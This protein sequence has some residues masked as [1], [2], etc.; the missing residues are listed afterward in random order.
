MKWYRKAAEQNNA[1]AQDNLGVCYAKGRGVKQDSTEAVKWY[2]KAAEQNYAL[3]QHNLGFCYEHGRGVPQDF[4]EAGKWYRKAAD[5]GQIRAQENLGACYANGRVAIAI[6]DAVDAY[7]YVKLAEKKGYEG[8]AKTMEVISLMLS[9][10][11]LR[12]A[13]RRYQAMCLQRNVP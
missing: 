1:V 5:Q 3:A 6:E 8:A 10:E 12:E 4:A 13:E 9:P 7:K 11:E 2:R